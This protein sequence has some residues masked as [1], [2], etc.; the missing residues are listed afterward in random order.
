MTLRASAFGSKCALDDEF[1]KKGLEYILLLFIEHHFF[2]VL[3]SGIVETI[4]SFAQFKQ[5]QALKKSD[6][7]KHTRITGIAKLDGK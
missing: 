6:G 7:K 5:Q 4:L 1:M 3:K 2:V